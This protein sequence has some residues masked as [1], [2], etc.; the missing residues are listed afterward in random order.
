MAGRGPSRQE[1]IRRQR[2][3]GFVG[4]QG[5]LA[6]FRDVLQQPPEEVTQFLFHIHGPG[7]VGKSTLV[8]QLENVA[9]EAQAVAGYVDETVADVVEVMKSISAQLAR[10]GAALKGFDRLLATYQQRRHEADAGAAMA[11]AE[12]PPTDPAAAGPGSGAPSPSPSSVIVSRIGLAGAGMIPGVGAFTGALDPNQVAA[13]AD[14]LKGLISARLRSHEDVQLVQSPVQALTPVFLQELAEAAQRRRWVV[15]FFDTYER[16]APLLDTWLRDVLVSERYGE[17][18]VNVLVVLAGQARLD[19][20]CWGDWLDLVADLPLEVFTESEARRLLAAKNVTDER[21]IEVI[22]QLSGR[23]PLLVS[24]LAEAHPADVAEVG[25]PSGTAVERFLKWEARPARRAVALACALPQELDEDVY[26]AAV[27]APEAGELFGW[28]RTMPFVTDRAGHCHYHD[29]VRTA[30]LRLQRQQ[31]PTRWHEQHTRLADTFQR[32]RIQREDGAEHTNEPWQDERWRGYRLQETYHRLCAEPHKALWPALRDLLDVQDHDTAS[33][34]RWVST[35]ARAGQDTDARDVRDWGERLLTALD[36]PHPGIAAMTLLLDGG[37]LDTAA[38]AYAHRLRGW[39]HVGAGNHEPALADFMTALALGPEPELALRG[40]GYVYYHT[41]RYEE[42]LADFDRVID[43]DP[44]DDWTLGSRG[45][46]YRLM[47]RHQEALADLDRAVEIDPRYAWAIAGRGRTSHFM[48]RYEEALAD[49]DRA[50]E[51]DPR[52]AWAIAGRG[53]TYRLMERYQEALADLDQAIGIDPPYPWAFGRRGEVHEAMGRYQQALADFDHA[54]E[55]S[56][57]EDARDISNRGAAYRLMGRYQ[58]ALA[59]YSRALELNPRS[60][61]TCI[62]RGLTHRL[63][64]RYQEALADFDRAAEL[65]SDGAWLHYERAVA[66]HALD[67]PDRDRQLARVVELIGSGPAATG[68]AR[69]AGMGN[70]VLA[71]SAMPQWDEAEHWLGAFLGSSPPPG[72]IGELLIAL[73]SLVRVI[74]SAGARVSLLG[75][76]LFDALGESPPPDLR[77]AAER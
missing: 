40:R 21:V 18:P 64:G 70:L 25:D 63:L 22:L 4:R 5:E 32:W 42:A 53:D 77:L 65:S 67:H 1:L 60:G 12:R 49:Y 13:G 45:E 14:Q 28:L 48:G 17:L 55:H 36:D 10:Q 3:S 76:R 56:P 50:I 30:M 69:F 27:D 72:K 29:V 24:M 20:Q 43:A 11:A 44:Q 54:V 71:Y 59:D 61:S 39:D 68:S 46:T 62:S 52:Y 9:R 33:L 73:N 37:G 8:R 31:S 23:L 7:G 26:R 34:R 19:P 38:R 15:L 74:P 57:A 47:G 51:I 2:R 41:Q 35:L 66:L 6:S 16:T 75:A 58:E